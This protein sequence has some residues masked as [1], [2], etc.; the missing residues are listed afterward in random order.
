MSGAMAAVVEREFRR[1][2]RQRGRFLSTLARPLLWLVV[3]GSGFA[4]VVPEQAGLSYHQY[5]LPGIFGM[6]ILF[7]TML[8]ALGTVHD[9]EFGAMR[10]LLVA[11]LS[12]GSVVIAK[13]L[14]ATLVGTAQALLLL[15]LPFVLDLPVSLVRLAMTVGAVLLTALALASLGML[16]A[17]RIRSIENFAVVMNFVLFPMFFLSGA[18]YPVSELPLFLQPLVRVNPLTY[19]VDLLKHALLGPFGTGM[20]GAEFAPSVSVA[21]L[22]VFSVA[23]LAAAAA[24]FGREEHLAR[25]LLNGVPRRSTPGAA[26]RART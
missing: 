13:A 2:A 17:S 12:R 6:V 19:G 10:M 25:I 1:I 4:S 7:S 20:L 16:C 22:A 14:A 11:P 26:G 21:V 23:A 18:L 8:S 24:L 15:P 3:I 5:L 9:R